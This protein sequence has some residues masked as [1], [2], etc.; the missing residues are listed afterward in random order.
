MESVTSMLKDL[1]LACVA[2][3]N[4]Y[5]DILHFL[6]SLTG[7]KTSANFRGAMPFSLQKLTKHSRRYYSPTFWLV[8]LKNTLTVRQWAELRYE[9]CQQTVYSLPLATQANLGWDIL[10][11][12]R[13]EQDRRWCTKCLTTLVLHIETWTRTSHPFKFRVP[14]IKKDVYKFSYLPQTIKNATSCSSFGL[15]RTFSNITFI[16]F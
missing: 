10:E 1:G 11:L 5:T 15:C 2:C 12:R 14:M 6:I 3:G 7:Q 16:N 4:E 8:V 9:K 13:K